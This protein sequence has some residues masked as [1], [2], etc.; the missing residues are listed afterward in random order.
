MQY[1]NQTNKAEVETIRKELK[2][3]GFNVSVKHS[4]GK[5]HREDNKYRASMKWHF[6]EKNKNGDV[7]H[8]EWFTSKPKFEA[9]ANNPRQPLPVGARMLITYLEMI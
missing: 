6:T 9:W 8:S 4:T 5:I 7:F 3:D 1:Y 2:S